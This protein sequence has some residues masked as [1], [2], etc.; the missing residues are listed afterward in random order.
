M[1]RL[2]LFSIMAAIAVAA[3]A[4]I[5]FRS[6]GEPD[7]ASAHIIATETPT[8]VDT[9]HVEIDMVQD[10]GAGTETTTD[11]VWCN[12]ID[13]VAHHVAGAGAIGE[14]YKVAICLTQSP[15]AP[16]SF[17]VDFLYDD[18]LNS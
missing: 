15:G 12:P 2:L 3:V 17:N 1:K 6:S 9:P 18:T 16:Q 11:D 5:G 14:T 4:L 13:T 7:V 10:A 8:G